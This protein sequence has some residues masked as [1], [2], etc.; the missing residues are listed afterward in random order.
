MFRQMRRIKQQ[1]SDAE[2]E[3]ILNRGIHGTLC[4]NGD[5]G[6]P[7]GVP[8]SYVWKNGKI[9]IHCAREGHKLDAI[10]NSDKV[11]FSVIDMDDVVPEKFT[12]L[13]RS[14]II[15]GRARVVTEREELP[16]PISILI[17]KYCKGVPYTDERMESWLRRVAFIVITPEHITGKEAIE[18]SNMK[19]DY[20]V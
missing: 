20:I 14:V 5:D 12:T 1:L 7:Y 13:F 3:E 15:F 8:V 17:E 18:L 6:Y 4:V 16:E 10:A 19:R 9:Y 11:T 2:T